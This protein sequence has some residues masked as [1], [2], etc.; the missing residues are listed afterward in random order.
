M[1]FD[2]NREVLAVL[3]NRYVTSEI[4]LTQFGKEAVV[5]PGPDLFFYSIEDYVRL[6]EVSTKKDK[7]TLTF[8]AGAKFTFTCAGH[9]G[10]VIRL[11]KSDL[12]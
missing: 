1:S 5:S 6:S 2:D 12:K 9:K 3:K 8:S 11:G 10:K 4:K 7:I